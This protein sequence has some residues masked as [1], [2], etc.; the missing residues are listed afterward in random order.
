[1]MSRA[2]LVLISLSLVASGCGKHT[3][4][5]ESVYRQFFDAM[6]KYSRQ[7]FPMHQKDAFDLLSK[8]SK[9]ELEKSTEAINASL[10]EKTPRL[11][12]FELLVTRRVRLGTTIQSV[13]V[14]SD[15]PERV[16]LDVTY[17]TGSDRVTLVMEDGA[18]RVDLFASEAPEPA[19]SATPKAA[20]P[21]SA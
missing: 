17:D 2:A 4:S 18:W 20:L 12:P 5:P 21:D 16:V 13:T 3:A 14:K 6:V 8:S 1:M 15:A 19:P 10:P 7:P 9:A 11:N